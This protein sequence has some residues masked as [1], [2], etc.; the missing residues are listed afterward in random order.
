MTALRLPRSKWNGFGRKT[1]GVCQLGRTGEAGG[2]E[3]EK[4]S[5]VDRVYLIMTPLATKYARRTPTVYQQGTHWS[6]GGIPRSGVR[7]GTFGQSTLTLFW[8]R[9]GLGHLDGWI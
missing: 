9:D 2:R 1:R 7:L 6:L 8:E 3:R 5:I 4:P